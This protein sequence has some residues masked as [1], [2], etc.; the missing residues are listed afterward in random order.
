[1]GFVLNDKIYKK[2][3]ELDDTGRRLLQDDSL[4]AEAESSESYT[5]CAA[6]GPCEDSD[7]NVATTDTTDDGTTSGEEEE[8]E[9]DEFAA[10]MVSTP[11]AVMFGVAAILLAHQA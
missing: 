2:K 5:E 1:M 6:E 7:E 9:P 10:G 8:G 4:D 11:G 3:D